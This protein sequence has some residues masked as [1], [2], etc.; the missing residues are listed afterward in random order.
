LPN[1]EYKYY[2]DEKNSFAED[3]K[4]ILQ[5]ECGE[6]LKGKRVNIMFYSYFFGDGMK[7]RPY[8]AGP[9]IETL[10]NASDIIQ[11]PFL[12]SEVKNLTKENSK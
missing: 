5:N 10:Q 12:K 8:N 1:D 6:L 3:V 4:I 7:N 9:R 2:Q 11:I